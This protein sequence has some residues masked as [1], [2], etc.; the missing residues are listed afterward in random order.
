MLV[1]LLFIIILNI[2][3]IVLMYY[4]LGDLSKKE[5][6]IFIAAGTAIM[7]VIISVVYW[8]ST[9]NI[10]ITEVSE[11]GKDLITFLFVP[12][13]GILVLP[14]FAKSYQ[15][16]KYGNIDGKI[17]RNRGIFIGIFL[18]IILIIECIYF[19]NIQEQVVNLLVEQQQ[20]TIEQ[21]NS[22]VNQIIESNT[23][24]DIETINQISNELVQNNIDEEITNEVNNAESENN[25]SIGNNV[26]NTEI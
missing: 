2:V 14:L 13:N 16:L 15:K 19:K 6:L 5:K 17:L 3:S 12:I 24:E 25:L 10:E 22:N 11:R 26:T 18:L 21:E 7:Y 4:S 1:I 20:N 23:L 8:F 9:R